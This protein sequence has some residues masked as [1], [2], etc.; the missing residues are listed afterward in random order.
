MIRFLLAKNILLN[1]KDFLVRGVLREIGVSCLTACDRQQLEMFIARMKVVNKN[2]EVFDKLF[3][4][5]WGNHLQLWNKFISSYDHW[6]YSQQ[7]KFDYRLEDQDKLIADLK[8]VVT[9]AEFLDAVDDRKAISE[10]A[11]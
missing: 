7:R 8:E 1:S 2:D 5:L 9:V 6:Y 10:D 3:N 11:F 4:W